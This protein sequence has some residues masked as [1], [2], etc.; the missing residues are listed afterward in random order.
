MSQETVRLLAGAEVEFYIGKEE[1]QQAVRSCPFG[2]AGERL[3]LA[4]TRSM[5][6]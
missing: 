2:S 4:S 1:E 6:F 5:R 3:E